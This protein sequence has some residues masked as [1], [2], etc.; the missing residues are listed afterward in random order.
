VKI[1]VLG[2]TFL[3]A[4]I[5]ALATGTRSRTVMVTRTSL[6]ESDN[7]IFQHN[8]RRIYYSNS[9]IIPRPAQVEYGGGLDAP[10]LSRQ[11]HLETDLVHA[12]ERNMHRAANMGGGHLGPPPI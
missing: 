4:L 2:C 6:I 8:T 9:R 11:F 12:P 10:P 1:K 7:V 3:V 5:A